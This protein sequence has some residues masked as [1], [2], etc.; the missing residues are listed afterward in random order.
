[1]RRFKQM[2]TDAQ[3]A[4]I[5]ELLANGSFRPGAGIQKEAGSKRDLSKLSRDELIALEMDGSLD[6]ELKG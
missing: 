5:N 2:V 6:A 4:K 1:M 3:T